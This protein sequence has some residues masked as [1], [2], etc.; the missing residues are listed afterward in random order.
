MDNA[1]VFDLLWSLVKSAATAAPIAG[2]IYMAWVK[3]TKM[4]VQSFTDVV[5]AAV[6]R[7][8]DWHAIRARIE[9]IEERQHEDAD[10]LKRIDDRIDEIY[11]LL[12][13]ARG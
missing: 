8:D 13:K 5:A 3:H 9:V 10:T 6:T 1:S 11:K 4:M 2:G 12:I 7:R